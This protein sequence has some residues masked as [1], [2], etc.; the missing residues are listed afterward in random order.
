MQRL[1]RADSPP[2]S[3]HGAFGLK[4]RAAD[5][6]DSVIGNDDIGDFLQEFVNRVSHLQGQTLAVLDRARVTLPQVLLLRRLHRVAE[7]SPSELASRMHMSLPAASQMIDR[8]AALCLL[9]RRESPD[10]RRRKLVSVTKK[11]RALLGKVGRAPPANIPLE[12]RNFR[13]RFK[14]IL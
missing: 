6:P 1:R 5:A 11:G 8:L 4:M 12:F 9:A 2:R 10:D 14:S 7:C 13:A 3:R